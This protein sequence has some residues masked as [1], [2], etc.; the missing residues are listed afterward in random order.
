MPLANVI[1][2]LWAAGTLAKL[3]TVANIARL[4]LASRYPGTCF[5]LALDVA[6]SSY[7]LYLWWAFGVRAYGAAWGKWQWVTIATLT[8]ICAESVHVMAK[9]Y[10]AAPIYKALFVVAFLS[11]GA[12]AAYGS[13]PYAVPSWKGPAMVLL[14]RSFSAACLASLLL[15]KGLYG[16]VTLRL[17]A[18][19][20]WRAVLALIAIEC[21]GHGLI[22][23][24]ANHQPLDGIGHIVL[25]MA[26]FV[27]AAL[28]AGLRR[29]G[30]NWSRPNVSAEAGTQQHD[31][32]TE[33]IKGEI[34]RLR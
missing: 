9:H 28:W 33:A 6:K 25:R 11:F 22:R 18:L 20:N 34:R 24:A 27:A 31:K 21:I 12:L 3:A 17:N 8:I 30:E 23:L 15:A 32:I 16:T 5:A 7:L 19:V 29:S 14:L 26:P 10:R 2:W 1:F 4:G 13:S